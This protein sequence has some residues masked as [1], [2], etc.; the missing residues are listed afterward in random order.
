MRNKMNT[1]SSGIYVKAT[2]TFT[3]I[4]RAAG[5]FFFS[6]AQSSSV[7][8][9]NPTGEPI[10]PITLSQ[11]GTM[12]ICQSRAWDAKIVTSAYW[13]QSDQVSK[14]AQT[15]EYLTTGS[16]MIRGKKNYL[17]PVQ[18]LADLNCEVI[19]YCLVD[20]RIWIPISRGSR[21]YPTTL[22]RT[23][24]ASAWGTR[25]LRHALIAVVVFG[26]HRH[27]TEARR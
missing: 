13:V 3:P 21:I 16:F 8:V 5:T 17:P 15:G 20:V 27:C 12:A 14:T 23:S 25:R 10:P 22:L 2:P 11:A 26:F 7:I 9:K 24:T 18:V 1:S 4:L 19:S 6:A